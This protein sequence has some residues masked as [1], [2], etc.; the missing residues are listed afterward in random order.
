MPA[1]AADAGEVAGDRIEAAEIVQKPR[2]DAVG[3]ERCLHGGDIQLHSRW[4]RGRH[5]DCGSLPAHPIKYS[6]LRP[7]ETSDAEP[8]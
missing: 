2:I 7:L 8:T 5:L 4:F 3:L 6:L 1:L